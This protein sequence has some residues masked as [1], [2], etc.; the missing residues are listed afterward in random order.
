MMNH[1]Q[2]KRAR[3]RLGLTVAELADVLGHNR[4]TIYRMERSP[5]CSSYRPVPEKTELL[6]QAFLQGYRPPNWPEPPREPEPLPKL[7][8]FDWLET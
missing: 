6:M 8:S 4:V 7:A 3:E 1:R 5:R 2:F